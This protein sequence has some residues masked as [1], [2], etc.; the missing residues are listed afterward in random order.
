MPYFPPQVLIGGGAAGAAQSLTSAADIHTWTVPYKCKVLRSGFTIT[1]ATVSSG[2]IVVEFDRLPY[3]NGTRESAF[4]QLTIPTA[5]VVRT[6]YYEDPSAEK[7]LYEGDQVAVQV[8]TAAAGGG[9]AGAG[10]PW[11]LVEYVPEVPGNNAYMT[12]C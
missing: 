12:A 3:N 5:A 7:L 1:T 8:A 4:A 2:N 9:A 10:V 6:V 11:M